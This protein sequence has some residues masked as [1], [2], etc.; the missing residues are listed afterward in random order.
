MSAHALVGRQR[1]Q[2]VLLQGLAALADGRGGLYL[3]SGEPG[4]GKTRLADEVARQAEAQGLAVAWGAAWDGGAAPAYW[5]WIEV[6]RS[7]RPLLPEPDRQLRRDL[8]P[9]WSEGS[10]T[11]SAQTDPAA[12]QDPELLGF[13]R[14]DALR[15]LVQQAAGRRPLLLILE[16][17]HAADRASLQALLLIARGVRR[18]PVMVLG[19]HRAGRGG[20]AMA[21]IDRLLARL[22][23][24]GTTLAPAPPDPGRGRRRCWTT[25][26]RCRPGCWRRCTRPAAATRCSWARACGWC[27]PAGGWKRRP[28]G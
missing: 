14:F 18:L 2:Q 17:L 19:T 5:P 9:L 12:T 16:D 10:A 15:A 20:G 25:W 3:L 1:E 27:A 24:E 23:R 22:A 28:R 26:I 4:I 11:E 7:L 13:R 8:G 21:E 6:V